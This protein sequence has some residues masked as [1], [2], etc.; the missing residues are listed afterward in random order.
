MSASI[1]ASPAV[2]YQPR[3]D[4]H[5]RLWTR[6]VCGWLKLLELNCEPIVH[7]S[8]ADPRESYWLPEPE[9]GWIEPWVLVVYRLACETDEE[10]RA[11]ALAPEEG[12]LNYWVKRFLLEVEAGAAATKEGK[13]PR[14]AKLHAKQVWSR[15]LLFIAKDD[16]TRNAISTI[17]RL[18]DA[19]D[20]VEYA[21]ETLI[22]IER[23]LEQCDLMPALKRVQAR[24]TYRIDGRASRPSNAEYE[25]EP[26]AA[27]EES[28][29]N[30]VRR[31][32]G[33]G[34]LGTK[35]NRT[36]DRKNK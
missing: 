32:R 27:I 15:L 24:R 23:R 4:L 7:Q 36:R 20:A 12:E 30:A 3:L 16:R 17:L 22:L 8:N 18:G 21:R 9:T 11:R 31:A 5:L 35:T 28:R 33:V 14:Y 34:P 1:A 2:S 29:E 13:P 6:S 25:G 10:I 19:D 26:A